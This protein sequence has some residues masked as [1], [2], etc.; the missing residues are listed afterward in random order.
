M[1]ARECLNLMSLGKMDVARAQENLLCFRLGH[2]QQNTPKE[3]S[4]YTQTQPRAEIGDNNTLCKRQLIGAPAAS[5]VVVGLT[6]EARRWMREST[7]L[8]IGHFGNPTSNFSPPTSALQYRR[9]RRRSTCTAF[10]TSWRSRFQRRIRVALYSEPIR[11]GRRM[12][13]SFINLA[14][15]CESA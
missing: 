1:R 8:A 6:L 9:G 7:P 3:R 15:N 4:S 14:M 5:P 2:A 13:E 10:P 11:K 12:S